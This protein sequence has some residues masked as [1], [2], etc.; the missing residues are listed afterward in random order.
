MVVYVS[1]SLN[2]IFILIL[3]RTVE[4]TSTITIQ[5]ATIPHENQSDSQKVEPRMEGYMT[6]QRERGEASNVTEEILN[7]KHSWLVDVKEK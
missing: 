1:R 2:R 3:R 7:S 5:F 6:L 4:Y